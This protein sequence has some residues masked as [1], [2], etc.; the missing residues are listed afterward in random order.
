MRGTGT[1]AE[2]FAE[3]LAGDRVRCRACQRRCLLGRGDLG[4]CRVRLNRDGRLL[5]LSYGRVAALHL[6]N[7]ERKPLF[8]FHP[9]KVML[10]VGGLGCNFR[11]PGCQNRQL[12]HAEVPAGLSRLE[13]FAPQDLVREAATRSLLGISFTYNEPAIWFE[14]TLD[15]FRLARQK[16]LLTNYVTNGSLT[17]EA[18]DRLGPFLDAYRVDIKGFSKETYRRVANFP[19]FRGILAV[20]ERAKKKWGMHVEC[21]T[22]VIPTLNDDMGEL[23]A[24]ARWIVRALGPDTPWHVTRFVPHGSLSHLPHTPVATL[25][26]GREIGLEEGLR[27]VYLGNVPGHPA[28]NTQCPECG[29]LLIERAGLE[30]C[31]VDLRGGCCPGCGYRLPG[32]FDD[33]KTPTLA[34]R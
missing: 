3:R 32:R 31:W 15:T 23:R 26:R 18:L 25:E 6:A 22:N 8:H 34:R 11:C 20:A 24:I 2:G 21:V 7:V 1:P 13:F 12:A 19:D 30:A 33:Y 4:L 5:S 27:F 14:Y 28:E 17:P 10:S 29:R 9:G 16:G